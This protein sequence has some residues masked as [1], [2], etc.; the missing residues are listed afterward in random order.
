MRDLMLSGGGLR[1]LAFMLF[2]GLSLLLTW[3][4]S[5]RSRG[6]A[7]FFV[8]GRNLS[9]V[10]N[11]LAISGDFMSAA[12]FLGVTGLVA[13]FGFDGLVYQVGFIAGWIVIML[14]VAEP[15]RNCG[16]YTLADVVARR[17][18]PRPGARACGHRLPLTSP[19]LTPRLIP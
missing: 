17:Q 7:G 18:E 1:V 10:Q 2:I 5:R 11:G 9:P 16:K 19:W 14:I 13:L 6:T 4:A 8:A 3:W 12:S 15:V